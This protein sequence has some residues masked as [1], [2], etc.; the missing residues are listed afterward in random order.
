M[1]SGLVNMTLDRHPDFCP[2]VCWQIL[3]FLGGKPQSCELHTL[4]L[5]SI[6]TGDKFETF[7]AKVTACLYANVHCF[8]VGLR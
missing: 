2:R 1:T 4:K 6:Q 7:L 5:E 8:F 3:R